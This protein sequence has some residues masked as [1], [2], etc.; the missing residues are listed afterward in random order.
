[1]IDTLSEIWVNVIMNSGLRRSASHLRDEHNP[2]ATDLDFYQQCMSRCEQKSTVR[3]GER[4]REGEKERGE[5]KVENGS[6][7]SFLLSFSPQRRT[8]RQRLSPKSAKQMLE[9]TASF[10]C[11]KKKGH[12][13]LSTLYPHP[14]IPSPYSRSPLLPGK[15]ALTLRMRTHARTCTPE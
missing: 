12:L 10:N 1:M 3:R 8:D 15:S 14:F 4:G 5:E 9:L 2:P 7:C 6:A 13:T 11:G